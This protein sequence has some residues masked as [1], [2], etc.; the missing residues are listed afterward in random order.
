MS[1]REKGRAVTLVGGGRGKWISHGFLRI[2]AKQ[3]RRTFG[4]LKI[5]SITTLYAHAVPC[6]WEGDER[7]TFSIVEHESRALEV[8]KS[9]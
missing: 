4:T 2:V 3:R 6:S 8:I 9:T 7:R 1:R 5:Q